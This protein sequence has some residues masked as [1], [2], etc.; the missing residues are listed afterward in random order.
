MTVSAIG[1]PAIVIVSQNGQKGEAGTNGTDGAGFNNVRKA[2]IDNPLSWLY[3]NNNLVRI[4]RNVLTISRT[5]SGAYTDIYGDAQVASDDTP[6]EEIEGWFLNGDEV[7]TFDVF[8]NIPNINSDFSIIFRVGTYSETSVS[9]NIILVPAVVGNLLAIGTDASGNWLVTLQGSDTTQYEA[10]TIISATSATAKTLA[11]TYESV[12]GTLNVY[13]DSA[14]SGTV[15]LPTFSTAA[16]DL[17]DSNVTIDGDFDINIQGLRFYDFL[18]NSDE[19]NY[20]D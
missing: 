16:M 6:R 1:D 17:T 12:T 8:D 11:I 3:S 4:L 18:L 5:T 14:L 20:L 2:L 15:I 9:Q 13:I 10:T 19:I 7:H